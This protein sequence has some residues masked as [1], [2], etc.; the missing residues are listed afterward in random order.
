MSHSSPTGHSYRIAGSFIW[1]R[2]Y[3]AGEVITFSSIKEE[4]YFLSQMPGNF[5]LIDETTAD[6]APADAAPADAAPADAATA[7]AAPVE[8]ASTDPASA[9]TASPVSEHEATHADA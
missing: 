4:E 3:Q 7:A 6:A 2:R 9:G 8:T 1:D 5:I